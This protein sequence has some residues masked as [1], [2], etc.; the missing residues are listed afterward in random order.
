MCVACLVPDGKIE[1]EKALDLYS[2]MKLVG[3]PQMKS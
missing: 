3:F 2:C 1:T